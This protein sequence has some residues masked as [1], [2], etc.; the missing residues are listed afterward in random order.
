MPGVWMRLKFL[1]PWA[2]V[3]QHLE[4]GGPPG[5]SPGGP[6]GGLPE[7]ERTPNTGKLDKLRVKT[8]G[9]VGPEDR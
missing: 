7:E 9:P 4:A 5:G 8:G 6:P 2:V 3:G 1:L